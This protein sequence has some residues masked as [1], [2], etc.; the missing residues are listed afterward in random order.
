[1][2]EVINSTKIRHPSFRLTIHHVIVVQ[3]LGREGI[4]PFSSFFASNQPFNAPLAGLFTEYLVSCI[5]L[6]AVPPGDAYIFLINSKSKKIESL[7]FL[8]KLR[9]FFL[10]QWHL[11]RWLLLMPWFHLVYSYYTCLHIEFGTGIHLFELQ[12]LSLLYISSLTFSWWL[13]HSFQQLQGPTRNFLTGYVVLF[14]FFLWPV[15]GYWFIFIISV[16]F[17]RQC[18]RYISW[19]HILV[20][21][22]YLASKKE[23]ISTSARVD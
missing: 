11:M 2:A 6:I 16:A 5:Y 18:H 4:L 8:L 20:Y 14:F 23:R 1:M 12:K 17:N 22:G 7:F 10:P 19:R 3:E 21:M 13:C 15:V 9:F